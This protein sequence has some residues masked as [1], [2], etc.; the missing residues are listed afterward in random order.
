VKFVDMLIDSNSYG[1]LFLY[2][3]PSFCSFLVNV[4]LSV[5]VSVCVIVVRPNF[6]YYFIVFMLLP[7]AK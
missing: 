2:V 3:R 4:C 6:L 7:Y 1:K 5:C